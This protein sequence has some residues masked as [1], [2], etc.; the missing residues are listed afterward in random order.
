MAVVVD[1]IGGA[2]QNVVS[3]DQLSLEVGLGQIHARI[4]RGDH[5]ARRA[6]RQIPCGG[7]SRLDLR[8]LIRPPVVIRGRVGSG[9]RLIELREL[10]ARIS[11]E[12]TDRRRLG[13]VRHR[14]DSYA[15]LADLALL[16]RAVRVLEALRGIGRRAGG[17][18]F[19]IL[20]TA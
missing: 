11:S 5:N 12:R 4:E 10:D 20:G 14:D 1:R 17:R 19:G 8:P 9:D 16:G 7:R 15:Q 6:L 13:A 18:S 2:V 3:G